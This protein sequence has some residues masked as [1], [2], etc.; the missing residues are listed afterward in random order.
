[1]TTHFAET[2]KRCGNDRVTRLGG[3]ARRAD[4]PHAE[5]SAGKGNHE[6]KAAV[7]GDRNADRCASRAEVTPPASASG[8]RRSNCLTNG[9]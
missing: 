6:G 5:V 9:K 8:G 3:R 2:T 1:M 7:D 4:S